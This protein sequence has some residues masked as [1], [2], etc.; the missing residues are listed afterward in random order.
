MSNDF[1]Q[2]F[3]PYCLERQP[4]GTYAVLNRK[5]KPLGFNIRDHV[6]FG[7]YP[8]CIKPKGMNAKLATKLSWCGDSCTSVIYLYNDGCIPT[9]S[10]EHMKSYLDR[11]EILARLDVGEPKPLR[12]N[13]TEMRL[14]DL[15]IQ[16]A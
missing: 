11:L 6:V 1:R 16:P 12:P 10:A 8:I 9:S 7:D 14:Q 13:E 2:I 4:D 5:Y 3:L 15:S